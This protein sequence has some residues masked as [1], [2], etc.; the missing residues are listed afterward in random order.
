MR[1]LHFDVGMRQAVFR[2]VLRQKPSATGQNRTP[3]ASASQTTVTADHGMLV[4]DRVRSA[5]FNGF[6]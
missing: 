2:M 4:I 1:H 3:T 5:L 6:F